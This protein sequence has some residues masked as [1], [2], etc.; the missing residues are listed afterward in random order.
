VGLAPDGAMAAPEG[1]VHAAWLYAGP[2]PGEEGTALIDGHEG[3][4]DGIQAV[5]DDL[6]TLQA[7]DKLYVEDDQGTVITFVVRTLKTYGQNENPSEVFNSSDGKAH[8][9]LITCN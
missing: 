4:K 2:R 9:N 1:P 6:D 3:W 8:L 5:F 7:G